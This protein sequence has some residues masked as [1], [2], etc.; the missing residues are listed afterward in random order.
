MRQFEQAFAELKKVM[1]SE[2]MS[3]PAAQPYPL[4]V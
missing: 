4:T 1:Q 2:G 3:A